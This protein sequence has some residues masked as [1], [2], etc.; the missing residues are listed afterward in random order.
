MGKVGRFFKKLWGGVKKGTTKV[1]NFGKKAV[2]KVGHVLR[3][4]ADVA[5]KVGGLMSNL[6]GKAGLI[7]TGLA[8]GG[9]TIKTITDM[10]PESKAKTKI[11]EAISKGVDTGQQWI[12]KGTGIINDV[13]NKVQPWIHSGVNIGRKL[14]DGAD[15]LNYKV[16]PVLNKPNPNRF[17][18]PKPYIGVPNSSAGLKR[19]V[20]GMP[21]PRSVSKEEW[22]RRAQNLKE[23]NSRL[24]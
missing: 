4:V 20:V 1:W 12:N 5:E 22:N 16:F 14:A 17:S 10:L 13:N 15:R 2:Q 21:N 23:I 8:A 3:P 6:P 18:V 19:F 24:N 11:E 7:G 9:S